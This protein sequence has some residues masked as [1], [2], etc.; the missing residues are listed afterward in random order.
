MGCWG[1]KRG[2]NQGLLTEDHPSL[3]ITVTLGGG[4]DEIGGVPLFLAQYLPQA[5]EGSMTG[6]LTQ[7]MILDSRPQVGSAT[8]WDVQ[9][10]RKRRKKAIL[11]SL[12]TQSNHME[13]KQVT[14]ITL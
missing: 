13:R 14:E 10:W 9:P 5:P 8:T 11:H 3:K 2:S 6:E 12:N 7:R 4:G 1:H